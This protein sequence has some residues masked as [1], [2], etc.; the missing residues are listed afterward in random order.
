MIIRQD[1]IFQ[2]LLWPTGPLFL[3]DLYSLLADHQ[4][5]DRSKDLFLDIDPFPFFI[6]D[7]I[8]KI[9][10]DYKHRQV[11]FTSEQLRYVFTNQTR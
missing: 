6:Q 2:E 7:I 3:G 10:Y 9:F 11:D 4:Q 1:K 8:D 5:E